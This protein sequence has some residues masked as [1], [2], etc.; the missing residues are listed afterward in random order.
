MSKIKNNI[1]NVSKHQNDKSSF[2]VIKTSQIKKIRMSKIKKIRAM[3]SL[4]SSYYQW[5]QRPVG[6]QVRVSQVRL[7]QVTLSQVRLSQVRKFFEI[8]FSMPKRH[9][10]V[11]TI[12]YYTWIPRPVGDQVRVSQVR[13][14]QVR[15]AQARFG[16]VKIGQLRLGQVGLC[17][18][19]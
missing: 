6:G 1:E 15:I 16:Q 9:W 10:L 18:V 19:R 17:Q 4:P 14:G 5:I 8:D 7:G 12:A 11:Q 3:T 13:L 2:E